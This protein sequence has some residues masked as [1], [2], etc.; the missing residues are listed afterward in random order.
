MKLGFQ[1]S[2]PV[3]GGFEIKNVY[4]VY[5]SDCGNVYKFNVIMQYRCP[6]FFLLIHYK[7]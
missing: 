1:I 4:T 5:D 6:F 7:L 3:D 2:I